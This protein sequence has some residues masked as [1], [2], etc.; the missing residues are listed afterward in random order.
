MPLPTSELLNIKQLSA[1]TDQLIN[2]TTGNT[3]INFADGTA[4]G[5]VP[6]SSQQSVAICADGSYVVVWSSQNQDASG[7]SVIARR[8]SA[9]GLAITAE[10][11]VNQFTS[12][13]QKWARVASD[14]QG[15][16]VVTW[17]SLGQ[18]ATP[19]SV[20]A[21]RFDSQGNALG[22]EFRVNAG[23]N[24]SQRNSVVAIDW[25]SQAFVVAFENDTTATIPTLHSDDLMLMGLRWI[26]ATYKP[27]PLVVVMNGTQPSRHSPL[28]SLSLLGQ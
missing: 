22:N 6:R 15:N 14:S 28:D 27:I 19:S 11:Q 3:Q 16:F 25:Q 24:G 1:T 4:S 20:Y 21:R 9:S 12:G 18:D 13:D 8:F 7:W 2:T 26:P 10:L 5:L 17:T 23:S